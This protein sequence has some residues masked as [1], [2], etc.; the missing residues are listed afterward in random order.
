MKLACSLTAVVLVFGTNC[1]AKSDE[2]TDEA[3]QHRDQL[4]ISVQ[5]ICPVSGQKLGDHG[6]PIKVTVGEKREEIFLCCQGCLK[7]KIDPKHWATIHANMARAQQNLSCHEEAAPQEREVDDR[8]RT[9]RIRLLPALYG[10]DR[11]IPRR[12]PGQD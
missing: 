7:Q 4:H 1:V 2:P 9:S 11:G 3:Q 6:V 8:E 5:Q 10:E 12:L